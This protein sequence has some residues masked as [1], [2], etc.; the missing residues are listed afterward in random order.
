MS[1]CSPFFLTGLN[2]FAMLCFLGLGI[3]VGRLAERLV[4]R[5]KFRDL[6]HD[7]IMSVG[8]K[9]P[10][11]SRHDTAKRYIVEAEAPKQLSAKATILPYRP[12][13]RGDE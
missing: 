6:Y 4:S 5:H 8:N 13:T 11:E 9:T 3:V 1:D 7:L 12:F 2:A 10:G